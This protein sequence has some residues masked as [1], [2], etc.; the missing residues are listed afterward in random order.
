MT[1]APPKG[2]FAL[3]Y[4]T[5]RVG[6]CYI[7]MDETLKKIGLELQRRYYSAVQSRMD[8]RM[9][10]AVARL[11]EREEAGAS[12]ATDEQ[13]SSRPGCTPQK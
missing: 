5:V 13:N 9:I 10:D 6:S 1:I 4:G 11:E 8:W 7:S 2:E 12:A 3:D